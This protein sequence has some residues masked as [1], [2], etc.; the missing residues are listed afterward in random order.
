MLVDY[1]LK[2]EILRKK[3]RLYGIK[4][5]IENGKFIVFNLEL[6]KHKTHP[7][8]IGAN[9]IEVN[10]NPFAFDLLK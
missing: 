9:E 1:I 8:F 7:I 10:K 2:M 6:E 3:R 5:K 4:F